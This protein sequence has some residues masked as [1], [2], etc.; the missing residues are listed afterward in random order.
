MTTRS[1]VPTYLKKEGAFLDRQR[2]LKKLHTQLQSVLHEMSEIQPIIDEHFGVEDALEEEDEEDITRCLQKTE[3]SPE[4][5]IRLLIREIQTLQQNVDDLT[6]S[7]LLRYKNVRN[8][9][10]AV[11]KQQLAELANILHGQLS[12]ALSLIE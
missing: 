2:E 1:T 5:E 6:K 12:R 8:S 4:Q 9:Q 10:I 3:I 11:L 7:I